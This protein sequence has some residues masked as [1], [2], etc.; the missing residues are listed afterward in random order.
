MNATA[1]PDAPEARASVVVN[2]FNYG[3]YLPRCIDS[4]L[5]QTV[6]VEVIVV[7]DGSTDGSIEQLAPYRDRVHVI[8]QPNGGQGAAMN[9]G[10]AAATCPI[11]L[12][13]D[14]DD[15]MYPTRAERVID[16]M[17]LELGWVRHELRVHDEILGPAA[18]TQHG[19]RAST[20]RQDVDS[21]GHSPGATSGLA[22]SL[23]LL[24]RIGPVPGDL[25]RSYADSYLIQ[26]AAYL[27]ECVTLGEE[28]G[29]RFMH[30]G[31]IT[32]DPSRE[33]ITERIRLRAHMAEVAADLTGD[34]EVAR[35]QAW[36]Q[37][38]ALLHLMCVEGSLASRLRALGQCARSLQRA[39]MRATRKIAFLARETLLSLTPSR[40]FAA[41]W[42]RT[43]DGRRLLRN[44]GR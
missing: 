3:R 19:D 30:A 12:L 34:P 20:P 22:F 38:K 35:L 14:S 17:P 42:W 32:T 2:N 21:Y 29:A 37:R 18:P 41:L 36:W 15:W 6:A 16:A 33:R 44:P 43:S 8:A 9:A 1:P 4:C 10:I 28:L 31:Q 7:D 26:R 24:R 27:G 11:V 23:D 39:R 13:L 25:Y 5:S 40:W